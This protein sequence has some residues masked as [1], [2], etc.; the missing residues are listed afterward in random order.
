MAHTDSDLTRGQ[1]APYLVRKQF[2]IGADINTAVIGLPP[3][4]AKS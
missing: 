2:P 4:V 3:D 1:W